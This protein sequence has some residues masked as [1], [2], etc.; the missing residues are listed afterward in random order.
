M[1]IDEDRRAGSVF[2]VIR[3]RVIRDRETFFRLRVFV[4]G[5]RP[6]AKRRVRSAGISG[7]GRLVEKTRRSIEIVVENDSV[8]RKKT[9]RL[10]R[11]VSR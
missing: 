9:L 8:N 4:V 11:S 5:F 7:S 2:F 3:R 10:S 6:D 1:T